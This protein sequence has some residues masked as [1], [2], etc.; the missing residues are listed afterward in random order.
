[1][2]KKVLITAEIDPKEGLWYKQ[3]DVFEVL[4]LRPN[5]VYFQDT[6]DKRDIVKD[7]CEVLLPLSEIVKAYEERKKIQFWDTSV[8]VKGVWKELVDN[9]L[10]CTSIFYRV[11]PETKVKYIKFTANDFEELAERWIENHEGQYKITAITK[12]FVTAG[13]LQI[14]YKALV[15]TFNFYD[16]KKPVGKEVAQ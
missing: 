3:N 13:N 4:D 6:D 10:F 12:A 16:T 15:G 7:H 9:R 1:M 5:G 11:A 14:P 8:E 2:K